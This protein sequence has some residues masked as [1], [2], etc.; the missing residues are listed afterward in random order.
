MWDRTSDKIEIIPHA[1]CPKEK[2]KVNDKRARQFFKAAMR[3]DDIVEGVVAITSEIGMNSENTLY[4]HSVC[5]DEINH[6]D[7]DVTR[8]LLSH[9]GKMFSLGGLA[10]LPFTGITGFNAFAS[11]VP[12]D[13]HIFVFY[14]PHIAIC[15]EGFCGLYHREGQTVFT[16]ACG[17]AIGAYEAVKDMKQPPEVNFLD[18]DVQ[19]D[20]IKRLVWLERDRI[21][22][23]TVPFRE[24]TNLLFED[25][26]KFFLDVC[27]KKYK[28]SG[29]VLLLG[30]I[31]INQSPLD[32]F[33]PKQFLLIEP[34]GTEK[35]LLPRLLEFSRI[36][37]EK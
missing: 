11:H 34:D 29:K 18:F 4:A 10:G 36:E 9:F 31:Q 33:E 23:R 14:G 32:Y 5:P 17:A 21:S 24:L 2:E 19:M 20:H 35:D 1:I 13:G 26:N 3:D 15:P 37:K 12:E 30:G 28:H 25:I 16:P 22:K 27:R 6:D 7:G 8:D